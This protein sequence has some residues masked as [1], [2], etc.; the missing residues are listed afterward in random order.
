MLKIYSYDIVCQEIPNEVSLALN[1]SGCP[2]FCPGCHSPWLSEDVGEEMK[3]EL[4]TSLLEKYSNA[5][6]C[7]CFMG[8]D[9]NPKQIEETAKWIKNRYSRIKTAWYSGKQDLPKDFDIKSMDFIKLGP[10]I[11]ELGGLKSPTTNQALYKILSGG[12]ME[13]CSF[14]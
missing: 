14:I 11:E 8:G 10:Y 3:E 2:N 7:V 9:A 1:I 6:T 5:I 12:K 4:M 13:K